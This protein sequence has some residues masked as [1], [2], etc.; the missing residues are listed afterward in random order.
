[1]V[2]CRLSS[3]DHLGGSMALVAPDQMQRAELRAVFS[4]PDWPDPTL[5]A[6]DRAGLRLTNPSIKEKRYRRAPDTLAAARR[7]L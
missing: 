1:V 5:T 7:V 2:G 4:S 6:R 3:G